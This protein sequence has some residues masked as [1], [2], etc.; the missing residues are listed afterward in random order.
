[1]LR[2]KA[3]NENPMFLTLFLIRASKRINKKGRRY[4][5][6]ILYFSYPECRVGGCIL[7]C[8][9]IISIQARYQNQSA[10]LQNLGAEVYPSIPSNH[11]AGEWKAR[12]LVLFLHHIDES[13][14]DFCDSWDCGVENLSG[15]E[16]CCCL[17][18][19]HGS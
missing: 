5:L 17:T 4:E 10:I 2:V 1:L 14:L 8:D 11:Q 12:T 19:V 3:V 6:F 9:R 18:G 7:N 15:M 13:R 16:F